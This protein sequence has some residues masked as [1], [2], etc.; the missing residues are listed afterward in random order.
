VSTTALTPDRVRAA[1]V[2]PR[3]AFALAWSD[4]L[5][6]TGRSLRH[7]TR[8]MDQL[9]Q[10]F[11][12][13]IILL[14]MFRYLLGGAIKTDQ[15]YINYVISGLI[16]ISAGFNLTSTVIGVT[17]D[18]RNGIVE[19]FRSMPVLPPAV[20][21][22]HVTAAVLRTF[23]SATVLI[24]AGFLVGFRPTAGLLDWIAVVGLLTLFATALCW[25]AVILGLLAKSVEGGSGYGLILVFLPYL[26]SALVPTET[27]PEVV[28]TI[29]R[30]Q[31]VSAIADAVRS[32]LTDAPAGNS[33]WLAIAWWT[34][35]LVIAVPLAARLFRRRALG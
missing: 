22:A 33:I 35:I 14:L 16:V 13:P 18:M 4:C 5:V 34:A 24:V 20:L 11:S 25:V 15:T 6:L 23:V 28:G 19:R 21:V 30:Y 10:T 2:A 17:N 7:L 29:V 32:L 27:M 26:S 8:N 1:A 31:P 9:I 3:S 12:L